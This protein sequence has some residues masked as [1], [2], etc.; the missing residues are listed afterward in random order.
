M[1]CNDTH[2]H[3]HSCCSMI[4]KDMF[5]FTYIAI[6]ADAMICK[7]M[8][9]FIYIAIPADANLLNGYALNGSVLVGYVLNGYVL[10]GYV[11]VGYVCNSCW[12]TPFEWICIEWIRI[13][14]IRIGGI[15]VEGKGIGGIRIGGIRFEWMCAKPMQTFWMDTHWMDTY[16]WDTCWTDTYWWDTYWWDTFWMDMCGICVVWWICVGYVWCEIRQ[17]SSEEPCDETSFG[18]NSFFLLSFLTISFF[19]DV[20][21]QWPQTNGHYHHISPYTKSQCLQPWIFRSPVSWEVETSEIGYAKNTPR[22]LNF[23]EPWFLTLRLVVFWWDSACSCL[24]PCWWCRIFKVSFWQLLI[25][26]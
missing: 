22:R 14:W 2:T 12:C 24:V 11:L 7:D 16:W 19:R 6:P 23:N 1:T 21:I 13:A 8:F 20:N 17:Q 18:K 15:R 5:A 26:S 4:C 10:V 25:L 3:C 9:A